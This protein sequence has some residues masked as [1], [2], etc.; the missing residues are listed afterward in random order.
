MPDLRVIPLKLPHRAYLQVHSNGQALSHALAWFEELKPPS[1]PIPKDTWIECQTAFYEGLT[2]A[3][4]HAHHHLAK[5]TTIDIEVILAADSITI[6]IW[7][8]GQGFDIEQWLRTQPRPTPDQEG[9]RGWFMMSDI[10][11]RLSYT[12]TEDRRNCLKLIKY[13]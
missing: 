7:D 3:V 13:Y 12:H 4:R 8:Y 1:L 6:S 5:D 10:A 11:D 2:N 9:G